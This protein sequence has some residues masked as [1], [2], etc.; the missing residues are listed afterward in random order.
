MKRLTLLLISTFCI[1]LQAA[2]VEKVEPPFWWTGMKSSY[3][4]LLIYGDDLSRYQ[5]KVDY[6]GVRLTKSYSLDNTN[7]RVIDLEL[8]ETLRPGSF[9]IDFFDNN[10]LVYR[11]RYTLKQR[12]KGS[13]ER[14]GF[15]PSDLIY[16]IT[17]D[18]FINGDT[19]NDS[20]SHYRDGLDRERHD[21][22]HGGDL[23]GVINALDYIADMGFTQIWLNPVL[24]NAMPQVSYHGYS[25]TDYYVVD[26]RFGSNELYRELS[27]KAKAKGVGLIKDIILNHIGSEHWWMKDMPSPDWINHGGQFIETN[28]KRSAIN[29]PHSTDEDR[30]LFADGWFVKTMPDLN[31]RHPVVA[32]YLIQNSIW[33]VEYAGLSGIRLDTYS[34]SDKAFLTQYTRRLMT[35]YPNLNIVGEEW[36]YNPITVAYWQ[37]G[38][39]RKDGYESYLP[40]LFDFPLQ[41]ALRKALLEKETWGTGLQKIYT[42]IATDYIYGDP[43]NL[44]VIADNHDMSRIFTQLNHDEDLMKMAMVYLLTTRGIPQVF[45]GTEILMTNKGTEEHGIIRSDFPGGWHGD[46]VNAITQKGLNKQQREFQSWFK[47]LANW[48]KNSIAVTQGKLTHYAPADGVYVYFRHV[49]HRTLNDSHQVMV[50]MN[51]NA[52][53]KTVD[54][55]RFKSMLGDSNK[56]SETEFRNVLS[57]HRVSGVTEITVAAKSAQIFEVSL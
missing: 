7:Y 55:T 49:G 13:A 8:S 28:H 46:S 37:Q 56:I 34:Y 18:R 21:G 26:P 10:K 39:Y 54:L 22:R 57:E 44:V 38:S 45:Y 40:S 29:D 4:Q 14:Q 42:T 48:R 32:N 19:T 35:E 11:H 43:Y 52:E 3:L 47:R 15:N 9:N 53:S 20:L 33:W 36:A 23:Q 41:G 25:T 2:P 6:P 50:I 27:Q 16:L 1:L 24:E 5:V 12:E 31:Q 51:K 30:A 17:P